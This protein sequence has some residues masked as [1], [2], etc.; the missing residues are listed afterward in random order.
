MG[1]N[2]ADISV[3]VVDPTQPKTIATGIASTTGYNVDYVET[4]VNAGEALLR[5]KYQ[6]MVIEINAI[7]SP[8]QV[9]TRAAVE[10]IQEQRQSNPDMKIVLS[11]TMTEKLVARMGLELRKDYEEYLHRPHSQDKLASTL[12][13]LLEK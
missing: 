8:D 5:K 4:S 3:L 13:G 7:Q 2:R 10:M 9:Y 6:V 11:T 12:V 1:F